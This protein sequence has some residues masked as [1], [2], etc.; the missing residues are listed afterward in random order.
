MEDLSTIPRTEDGLFTTAQAHAAG[1][2]RR[3]LQGLVRRGHIDHVCRGVYG[4]HQP[5]LS[6]EARH[7]R[8]VRAGMLVYPD[9]VATH[10]SPVLAHGIPVFDHSL[11]RA[12]LSRDLDKE[13]LTASFRIRPG[14]EEPVDT[15]VG[16]AVPAVVA[17]VQLTLDGGVMP[18]VVACDHGLREGLFDMDDLEA[19]A[20]TVCGAPGHD[21]RRAR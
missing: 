9:A 21:P 12:C 16:P 17:G 3:V 11:D 7:L 13:V 6:P 1:F 8:L 19:V 15:A 18:G 4:D 14:G 10:V 5:D 20:A 2:G